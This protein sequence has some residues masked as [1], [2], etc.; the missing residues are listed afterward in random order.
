MT[1]GKKLEYKKV[2]QTMLADV[3]LFDCTNDNRAVAVYCKNGDLHLIDNRGKEFWKTNIGEHI[4]SISLSDT[5]EVLAVNNQKKTLL[6]DM[7]GRLLW[8]KRPF[9]A[10]AGQISSSGR[11]MTFITPDPAVIATDRNL[12]IKWAYRNLLQVP[13]DISISENGE[14]VAFPGKDDRGDG[15]IGIPLSGEPYDAFMGLDP[16]KSIEVTRNGEVVLAIDKTGSIFCINIAKSHGIW[17][18]KLD[19]AFIGVSY[20]DDTGESIVY[21]KDGLI[22]KLDTNGTP[23]WEY[24]FPDWIIKAFVSSDSKAIYYALQGGEIGCL[25]LGSGDNV[26]RIDFL[27]IEVPAIASEDKF[28]FKLLWSFDFDRSG[29]MQTTP[30]KFSF[31]GLEGVEYF[32]VWDGN[33][34]IKCLNDLGEEIWSNRLSGSNLFDVSV[35]A[36][37]DLIVCATARGIQGYDLSGS[38]TFKF[39]GQFTGVHLFEN[40]AM[41]L[42]D[43]R[44]KAKF[45][46]SSSHFSHL[47]DINDK[48][49]HIDGD[50]GVAVLQTELEIFSINNEGSIIASKTLPD[51][52]SFF[53]LTFENDFVMA[54]TVNGEVILMDIKLEE[55]FLYT[56][57]AEVGLIDYHKSE[58]AVYAVEKN[59]DEISVFQCKNSEFTRNK[60]TGSARFAS[61]HREG[62]IIGTEMDQIGLISGTGQI[63]ARYTFPGKILNLTSG[64]KK[65][66]IIVLSEESLTCYVIEGGKS[67][68]ASLGFLEI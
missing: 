15:I 17:K 33:D 45:Y 25:M 38:E 57:K 49:L 26:N 34:Q 59:S 24:R 22:S 58:D 1:A 39:L 61:C 13:A 3:S 23:I 21:T 31:M 18:G 9:A 19:A 63:L 51:K 43:T 32:I 5:L 40:G 52:C 68:N 10:L 44:G 2:W 4:A 16:V 48:V 20:A 47:L 41:I 37:S 27:E 8:E 60:L 55:K 11:A 28:S 35:S 56:L 64:Y 53:K 42:I 30:R 66:H 7:E 12:K 50:S 54:G 65:E 6:I 29:R 67:Q 46:L 62:A 14:T 36:T